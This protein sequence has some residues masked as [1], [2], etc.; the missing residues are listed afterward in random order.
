MSSVSRGEKQWDSTWVGL[1][2]ELR[3]LILEVLMRDGCSLARFATVSREW[4]T[5][6]ERYNFARIKLTP[7]RL[8][9]F[10]PMTRRNWALVGYI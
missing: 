4:Q 6:L 10:G 5:V 2:R 7:A 3:L 1:P 9:A 8:D